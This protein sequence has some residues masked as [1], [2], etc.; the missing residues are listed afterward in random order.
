MKIFTKYAVLSMM[1]TFFVFAFLF[2]FLTGE[3]PQVTI[4]LT[5][6]LVSLGGFA[7]YRDAYKEKEMNRINNISS[8]IAISISVLLFIHMQL[9]D[10][11]IELTP[12]K[13][14][15]IETS[16]DLLI[17]TSKR[18][19]NFDKLCS[20]KFDKENTLRAYYITKKDIFG[21]T[22]YKHIGFKSDLMGEHA[23]TIR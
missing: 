15:I 3:S 21:Y 13:L 19:Y 12:N 23:E 14:E 10:T 2:A 11:K 7:F 20:I 9:I 22:I 18:N 4:I 1:I 6:F 16:D 17:S 5:F 8:I